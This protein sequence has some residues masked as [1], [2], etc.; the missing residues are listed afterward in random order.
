MLN[1]QAEI[2]EALGVDAPQNNFLKYLLFVSFF[3]QLIQGPINR[4]DKMSSSLLSHKN[5]DWE[6]FK[7]GL[8]LI[9]FGLMKKFALT[10]PMQKFGKWGNSLH[11]LGTV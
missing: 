4:Y 9:L 1:K 8:W 11:Y 10:K 7:R 3:P 6:M 2:F 5:F